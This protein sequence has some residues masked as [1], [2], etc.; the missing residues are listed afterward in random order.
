ML[1][2]AIW[3]RDEIFLQNFRREIMRLEREKQIKIL[4]KKIENI[5]QLEE[6][7]TQQFQVFFLDMVTLRMEGELEAIPLIR[8]RDRKAYIILMSPSYE[9][10]IKNYEEEV[11]RYLIKPIPYKILKNEIKRVMHI[12]EVHEEE[13]IILKE[14]NSWYRIYLS[15]IQ[16]IETAGR[17]TKIH[18]KNG[19]LE[20]KKR[21]KEYEKALKDKDFVRCHN[22]YIVNLKY[23]Q[24]IRGLEAILDTGERVF[25]SKTR[26]KL[27]KEKFMKYIGN[28]L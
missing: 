22:S 24:E 27:V 2:I 11:Y 28:I 16:Y 17:F 20:T 1:K 15:D 18:I 8:K 14:R 21:M 3:D 19:I 9:Y 25:I 4:I 12:L 13:A 5:F 10:L 23:I 6:V 26:K 7:F